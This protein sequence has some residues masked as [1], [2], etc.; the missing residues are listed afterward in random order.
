M[1][2]L[3]LMW[4]GMLGIFAVIVIIMIAVFIMSKLGGG[5]RSEKTAEDE[6]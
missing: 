4:K 6:Q 1:Q 3:E 2:A 5:K